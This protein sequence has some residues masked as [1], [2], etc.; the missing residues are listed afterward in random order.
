MEAGF[1]KFLSLKEFPL[2]VATGL[3]KKFVQVVKNITFAIRLPEIF[4]YLCSSRNEMKA[5]ACIL[6]LYI[7]ILTAIPC[8]DV[9][10]DSATQKVEFSQST[11]NHHQ[12]NDIDSCSPFCV[13]SCCVSPISIHVYRVSF[14]CYSITR[15]QFVEYSSSFTSSNTD[16]IWQPPKLS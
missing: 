8:V 9:P 2:K 13:C 14:T 16:S 6:S 3:L 7:L 4:L 1:H 5:F 15:I 10:Q 12:H 11:C